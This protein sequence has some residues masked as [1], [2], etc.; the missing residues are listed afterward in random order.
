M[1]KQSSIKKLPA[2]VLDELY[3][4]MRADRLSIKELIAFC[5]EKGYPISNGAMGRAKKSFGEAAAKLR[6]GREA[7]RMIIGE[8]GE[9]DTSGEQMQLLI[10]MINN[11]AFNLVATADDEELKSKQLADLARMVRHLASAQ[12]LT[13]EHR[14]EIR[15]EA[16]AGAADVVAEV[17]KA[18]GLDEETVQAFRKQILGVGDE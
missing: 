4:H 8:L 15:D 18:K 2:V 11:M 5:E 9:R 6:E 1:P 17:G 13:T 10:E 16:L 14:K 12:K 3:E 7:A